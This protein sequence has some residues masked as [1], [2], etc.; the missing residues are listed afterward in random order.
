[1]LFF[2][3]IINL[4]SYSY[5][6]CFLNLTASVVVVAALR[7]ESPYAASFA[8]TDAIRIRKQQDAETYEDTHT[9]I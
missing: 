2:V 7:Y 5:C 9:S 3:I 6:C 8:I 1:M 4:Y